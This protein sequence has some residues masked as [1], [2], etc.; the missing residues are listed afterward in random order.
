[1]QSLRTELF[2][3]AL[4]SIEEGGSDSNTDDVRTDR[5]IVSKVVNFILES[6]LLRKYVD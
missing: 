3:N 5:Q 6:A 2:D 4:A 1:L